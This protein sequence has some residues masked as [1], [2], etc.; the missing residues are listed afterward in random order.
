[1]VIIGMYLCVAGYFV[2]MKVEVSRSR[3]RKFPLTSIILRNARRPFVLHSFDTLTL[4]LQ[5]DSQTGAREGFYLFYF[6]KN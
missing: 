4:K 2:L 6:F 1:M 5:P 3:R